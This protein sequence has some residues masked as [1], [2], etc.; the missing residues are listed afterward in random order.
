MRRARRVVVILLALF[1]VAGGAAAAG[2]YKW[3][4]AEGRV[5]FGD[6]PPT[7]AA[8]ETV[9][10][11]GVDGPAA[12]D[13]PVAPAA[14]GNVVLYSTE[15]C[16]VCNRAK[17]H[18]RQRGVVFTEYDIE[19]NSLARA[20]F[21]RLGGRGVPLISVGEKRMKGFNAERLDRMLRD[22]GWILA[23]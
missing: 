13:G 11:P 2:V 18:L 10:I 3:T 17:A 8:S 7:G 22:A 23:E 12:D 16:G 14:L 19:K 15:W 4:D 6:R 9:A 21:K 1:V 5:H 20:E